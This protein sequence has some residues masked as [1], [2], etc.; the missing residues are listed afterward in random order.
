MNQP[1]LGIDVSKDKSYA[2]AYLSYGQPFQKPVMFK[3]S[4]TEM[5]SL[6]KLLEILEKETGSK[7]EVVLEATGRY[8]K[9]IVSFFRTNG[10][11]VIELNPSETHQVRKQSIRKVKTD[12]KESLPD[13]TGIHSN[14]QSILN[15]IERIKIQQKVLMDI[16]NQM[17]YWTSQSPS[18]ELL[19]SISGVGEVTASTIVTEIGD[20]ERFSTSKQ[21]VA[22]TRL[23]PSVFESRKFKAS[24]NRISKRGSAYLRNTI[25]QATVAAVT[26]RKNGPSNPLLFE[27]YSKKLEEGKPTR[28]ALIATCNKLI[29]MIYGILKNKQP[30]DVTT[31]N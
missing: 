18:Y 27:Y 15:Y 11:G 25:Y 14:S 21:L 22:F 17:K 9:P 16:R 5:A 4:P 10:Y 7:P 29:R 31:A 26:K 2:V 1:I 28:V 6:I 8:S 24:N 20:V 30:F 12:F 13:T 23:D 19:L 3:H